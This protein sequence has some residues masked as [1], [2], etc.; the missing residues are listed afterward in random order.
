MRSLL[1]V[2][3]ATCVLGVSHPA[4]AQGRSDL[5]VGMMLEPPSLDP[6]AEAAAAVDEVLYANVFEGLVRFA[7][8][9]SVVPGLASSWDISEDGLSYTFHLRPQVSFHDGSAMDS[10]DVKFSLDRINAEGS[11][12]AQKAL[13]A[14]IA[15]VEAVNPL[16]VRVRLS[17]PNGNL[18]YNLA[19]GDAVIVA[20]ESAAGNKTS[21]VG[22]GPFRFSSRVEGDK[23]VLTRNPNY[24]G[25][26]VKLAS[27]TFRFIGDPSAAFAAL[28][29][30][31]VDVFPNYPAPETLAQFSADPRFSVVVGAMPSETV[32]AMNNAKPPLDR[33]AV[34]EAIAHAID[35]QAIIEGSMFGYGAPIGSF[36][37]PGDANYVDLTAQS[38]YDPKRSKALL[39]EVGWDPAT[40]LSLKVPPVEAYRRAAAIIAE[41]LAAVGS[42][43]RP[44]MS[45]GRSG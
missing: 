33:V 17:K 40:V 45:N 34:R 8:D 32:L 16:T 43:P 38:A 26:P 10:A 35:R 21:P 27:A 39:A 2:L 18:I 12:N 31:D 13:Y 29:A 15:A 11:L 41:E 14:D 28:E 23:I 6:T 22:T 9:G 19:W 44:P 42:R 30:G 1:L 37:P 5:I 4:L 24:W 3:A 36:Y 20:P 7:P 25:T